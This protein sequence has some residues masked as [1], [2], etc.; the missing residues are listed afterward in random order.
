MKMNK[1][2][3]IDTDINVF[4]SMSVINDGE[5]S[6]SKCTQ[7]IDMHFIDLLWL[8]EKTRSWT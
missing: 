3:G 1:L 7:V 4:Q 5:F 8:P 6:I 2:K